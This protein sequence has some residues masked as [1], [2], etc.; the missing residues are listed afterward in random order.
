MKNKLLFE[1]S[2]QPAMVQWLVG[3]QGCDWSVGERVAY[4]AGSRRR[5]RGTLVW[6]QNNLL[7]VDER[8]GGFG[9]TYTMGSA[10][11]GCFS[12]LHSC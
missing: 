6:E 4:N 8:Y 11:T 2:N 1:V 3:G 9:Q 5:R 10:D 7:V 12:S